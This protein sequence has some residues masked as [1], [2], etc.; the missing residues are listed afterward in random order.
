MSFKCQ[1]V[2]GVKMKEQIE[3]LKDNLEQAYIKIEVLNTRIIDYKVEN[4]IL[5]DLIE[6]YEHRI[7]ILERDVQ[8]GRQLIFNLTGDI[9]QLFR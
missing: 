8:A 4:E 9:K 2:Y 6:S 1:Q 3:T 5:N 7:L